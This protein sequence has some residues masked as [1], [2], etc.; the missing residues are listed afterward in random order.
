[1]TDDATLSDFESAADG[2]DDER[3]T[4]ETTPGEVDIDESDADG[5]PTG[6]SAAESDDGTAL[7]TYAWG[8]YTCARCGTTT[9]RAWRD[10]GSFVCTGCKSW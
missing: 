4:G 9:E 8:T 5:D 3:A 2:A 6:S 1:M 10:E 7:S